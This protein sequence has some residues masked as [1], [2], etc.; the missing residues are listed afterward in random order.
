MCFFTYYDFILFNYRVYPVHEETLVTSSPVFA[1]LLKGLER[2]DQENSGEEDNSVLGVI[3]KLVIP[4]L[5]QGTVSDILQYIYTKDVSSCICITSAE[6]LHACMEYR[7]T[8]L[9]EECEQRQAACLTAGSVAKLLMLAEDCGANVLKERA[10]QFCKEYS[11]Y[12]VKDENWHLMESDRKSLWIEA[13]KQ[14]ETI[15]CREHWNCA[16]NLRYI[17]ERSHY[18]QCDM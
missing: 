14:V 5:S 9:Q 12:I 18:Q 16:K 10:L 1:N 6:L 4:Q 17:S 15:S 8:G 11:A 13:C 3:N 7:L 2:V